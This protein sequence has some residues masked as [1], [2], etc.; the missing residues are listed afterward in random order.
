MK[1]ILIVFEGIDGCGKTT[2]ADFLRDFL[3]DRGE[4]T[5]MVREPGGTDVSE[6]IRAILLDPENRSMS[7]VTESILLCA[8]R[9]QLTQEVILP[10]L[11]KGITVLCDRFVDSSVAYQGY[12][13]GLSIEW[14]EKVNEFATAGIVPHI[15]ILIDIPVE[16]ALSRLKDKSK[17]R[18]EKEGNR[19][20]HRVR[21]GYLTLAGEHAERYIV[22]D[23]TISVDLIHQ[24]IIAKLEERGTL[25]DE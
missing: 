5:V 21:E 10:N 3:N 2:Q 22:L 25:W 1:G 6:K 18:I 9:A 12:G 20:L 11:E 13:R 23:G 8:S 19:F 7:P 16:T 15:T 17:D 14:L 4:E 24:E